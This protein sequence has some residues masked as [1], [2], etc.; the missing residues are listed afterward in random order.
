MRSRNR[1]LAVA[2]IGVAILFYAVSVVRMTENEDRRHQQD[3]AA[4]STPEKS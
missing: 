2:L 1:A 3:P 4:H